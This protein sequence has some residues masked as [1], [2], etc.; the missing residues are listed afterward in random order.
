MTAQVRMIAHTSLVVQAS[1]IVLRTFK[2]YTYIISYH[3]IKTFLVSLLLKGH[4]CITIV[5]YNVI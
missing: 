4:R 1:T 5:S 2:D 3:I